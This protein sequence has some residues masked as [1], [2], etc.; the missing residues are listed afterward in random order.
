VV[1][2]Q[3]HRDGST[4]TYTLLNAFITRCKLSSDLDG[5]ASDIATEEVDFQ[6]EEF[7]FVDSIAGGV[8]NK[9][10]TV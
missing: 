8:T 3:K 5:N 9:P 2:V 6:Y 4:R 1:I 7:E 10:I